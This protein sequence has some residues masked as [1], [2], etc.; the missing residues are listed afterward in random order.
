MELSVS[1][2]TE[3]KKDFQKQIRSSQ[4]C[5]L[6]N[7][8]PTLSLLTAEELKE[9]EQLWVELTVWKKTQNH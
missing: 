9:L 1:I 4:S 7:S 5:D 3:L 6:V 2:V 8:Q